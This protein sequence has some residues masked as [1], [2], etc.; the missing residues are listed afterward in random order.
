LVKENSYI[1]SRGGL[2]KIGVSGKRIK[3]NVP[4]AGI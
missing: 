3:L 2:S 1:A 4:T